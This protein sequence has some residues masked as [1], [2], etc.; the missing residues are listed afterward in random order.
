MHTQTKS[1]LSRLARIK[2]HVAAV[3]RMVEDGRPCADVLVQI[4]A[5]RAALDK[6]AKVLLAD[7]M[8][9]CILDSLHGG[10]AEERLK[11]LREALQRFIT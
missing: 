4:S 10:N 9:H 6:T 1:V 5:V 11:E 2:G 8:E 3:E 7:H